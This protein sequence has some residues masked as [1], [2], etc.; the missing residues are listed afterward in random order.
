MALGGS[1][2]GAVW[3]YLAQGETR[4][5]DLTVFITGGKPKP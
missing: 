1:A 4:L 3:A 5:S 2:I